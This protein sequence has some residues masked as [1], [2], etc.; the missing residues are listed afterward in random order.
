[1]KKG[2]DLLALDK[3]HNVL[4]V[5]GYTN[6]QWTRK[7]YESGLFSIEIPAAQYD[8]NIKYVYTKDRPEMGI[9][10][11][12][13]LYTQNG[14]QYVALSGYFLESL[15]GHRI[16]FQKNIASDIVNEPSWIT[17]IGKAE[18]VATAFFDGFKDLH[19][20]NDKGTDHT[21][22]L[23]IDTSASQGRGHTSEHTRGNESLDSKIYTILKPSKMSYRVAYDFSAN[24]TTFSCW[25]G[26][27]RSS[28]NSEGNNPIVFSTKYGNITSANLLISS[29]DYK[30]GFLELYDY[31]SG[32]SIMAADT[33]NV[34]DD[35]VSLILN[36]T[37]LKQDDF[38][39]ANA[40]YQALYAEGHEA[41]LEHRMT[42]S[43]DFDT[44]TGSY[45][46]LEDFDLG[47]ICSVEIPEIGI[48]TDAVLSGI[49]E[50]VKAGNH[51]LSLE[52]TTD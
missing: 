14:Y 47:D 45:E 3:N 42:V 28:E 18:D 8:S 21:Y 41:L 30:N 9:V 4:G 10:T 46:Y 51:T 16:A 17:Q 1:M 13:N 5:L 35:E 49:Y 6:L 44:I 2:I 23:G 33:E 26:V 29:T 43:L 19:I 52:F 11:Q 12:T 25:H 34:E 40:F 31:D 24:T 37:S 50:V 27:D 39:T 22:K 7:F 48:S 20:Q 15:L 36:K 32:G 38:D